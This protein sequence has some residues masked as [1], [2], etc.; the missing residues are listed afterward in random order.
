[1]TRSIP[2]ID[3]ENG[4][5]MV[6]ALLIMVTLAIAGLMGTK[7]AV[8]EGRVGR[9]YAIHK[10]CE[11]AA[12]AAGKEF[13]QAIDS[14]FVNAF[15]SMDAVG[16]LDNEAW[17]PYDDYNTTFDFDA[18]HLRDG[19]YA[20]IKPSNLEGNIPYLTSAN[21]IAV[22]VDQTTSAMTPGLGGTKL[23]EYY[24]YVIYSRAEHAG[25][26]SSEAILMFGY[27]QEY[28]PL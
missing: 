1:M 25:A 2:C 8:M 28:T 27:R 10:Q 12:D 14:I 23:P 24:T 11:N 22:L 26:G 6:I 20:Q 15:S 4:S 3:N 5:L 19:T 9:N 13:I 7:D 17:T 16:D 18:A 21:A